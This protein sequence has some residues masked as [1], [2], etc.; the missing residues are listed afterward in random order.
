LLLERLR[1]VRDVERLEL[2]GRHHLAGGGDARGVQRFLVEVVEPPAGELGLDDL[3]QI[4]KP[5]FGSQV[6]DAG[7]DVGNRAAGVVS[8]ERVE[9]VAEKTAA[10]GPCPREDRHVPRDLDVVPRL[11]TDDR[12]QRRVDERRIGAKAGLDIVRRPLMIALFADD[13]PHEG[14]GIHH[15]GGPR[16][17]AG[18]LHA[19]GS[20]P[21]RLN[22]RVRDFRARVRVERFELTGASFHVEHDQ[23][24]FRRARRQFFLGPR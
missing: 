7:G 15:L 11:M 12:P 16:Q 18:N 19:L 10:G 4:V 2:L 22:A 9:L 5:P 3:L 20:R 17:P 21:D 24:L 23:A 1:S 14:D 6:R 8:L 13:G